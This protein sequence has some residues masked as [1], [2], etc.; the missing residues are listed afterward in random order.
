VFR[1]VRTCRNTHESWNRWWSYLGHSGPVGH[2]GVV[3]GRWGVAG[4]GVAT[5]GRGAVAG[6]G[7][8]AGCG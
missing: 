1:H 3:L 5:E 8:A 4:L 6:R 2:S 7:I